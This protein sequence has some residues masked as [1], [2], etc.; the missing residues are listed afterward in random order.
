MKLYRLE[1]LQPDGR[2]T[3]PYCAEYMTAKAFEL[4]D[5]MNTEH[6]RTRVFPDATIFTNNPGKDRYVCASPSLQLLSQW[7]G[8]HMPGLIQEGGHIAIY[9]VPAAA[10]AWDD[11]LQIVY[12]QRRAVCVS[13]K[14]KAIDPV[15]LIERFHP[16][17]ASLS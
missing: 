13:R 14:G 6:L 1:F 15:R 17:K 16:T 5:A 3:G 2:W 7:F 9:E 8:S 4:R 10:I 11:G 12:Q